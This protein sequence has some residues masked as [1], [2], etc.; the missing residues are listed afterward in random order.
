LVDLAFVQFL[1]I[2]SQLMDQLLDNNISRV[3][4]EI[5]SLFFQLDKGIEKFLSLE[6]MVSI[7]YLGNAIEFLERD[8]VFESVF[9]EAFNDYVGLFLAY[10]KTK[11]DQHFLKLLDGHL[12][13]TVFIV[14][15]IEFS[16]V[17]QIVF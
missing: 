3:L 8:V 9:L 11:A 14:K 16:T 10:V 13:V 15:R 5:L 7:V 4:F 6:F 2:L 12:V 1:S 17:N